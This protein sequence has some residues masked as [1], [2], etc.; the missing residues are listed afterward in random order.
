[1]KN[2]SKPSL[3]LLTS[4]PFL[5]GLLLLGLN[6][7]IWK[8]QF[9]NAFTGKLSDFAGL[10]T[11]SLF[12]GALFPAKKRLVYFLVAGWFIFWKSTY[13]QAL[14]D[15]INAL[16]FLNY[17]R[18]VDW[19]DLSALIVLPLAYCFQQKNSFYKIKIPAPLPLL[20]AA[21]LFVA[22]SVEDPDYRIFIEE[23]YPLP[24]AKHE[25]VPRLSTIDSVQVYYEDTI[26]DEVYFVYY[27]PNCDIRVDAS[28]TY[29]ASTDTTSLFTLLYVDAPCY[30]EKDPAKVEGSIQLLKEEFR[31]EVI[32]RL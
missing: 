19:T 31:N 16:T 30:K 22:T 32:D 23:S 5:V 24:F 27:S 6:D 1:M 18:V 3:G 15:Q 20:G 8:V 7:F 11:F 14:I 29:G 9:H 10:F 28:G 17:G 26:A 2:L 25:L 12:F 21:F 4:V 13:S